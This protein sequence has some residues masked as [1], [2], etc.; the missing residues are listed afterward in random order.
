M[1]SHLKDEVDFFFL[2]KRYNMKD[3]LEIWNQGKQIIRETWKK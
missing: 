1:L 2:T 3:L